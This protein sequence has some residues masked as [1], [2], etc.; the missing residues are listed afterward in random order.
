MKSKALSIVL[1]AAAIGGMA[2]SSSAAGDG[3]II[4]AAVACASMLVGIVDIVLFAA[5]SGSPL[6]KVLAAVISAG[7]IVAATAVTA[8]TLNPEAEEA[9]A[10][11]EAEPAVPVQ[12]YV[13]EAV[14][15]EAPVPE[16]EI[17]EAPAL[18]VRSQ[19]LVEEIPE[20]LMPAEVPVEPEVR[21][22]SAPALSVRSQEVIEAVPPA[23]V[24]LPP[25]P[26]PEPP[27]E[28]ETVV[29][30]AVKEPVV[31]SETIYGYTIT[32]SVLDGTAVVEYP[33]AVTRSD[34]EGF[35]AYEASK[36]G[37]A[38][39]GITYSIADGSSTLHIPASDEVIIQNVPQF[40]A[41]IAE[42]IDFLLA[43]KAEEEVEEIVVEEAVKEPVVISETIYGYTITVSVLDGTAVVEYPA[44]V[45]K[46]DAAGFY[47]YE[48]SKYGSAVD[49]I[50]YSLADGSSTLH[51]PASD[52]VIIQNVP[53]FFADIVEYIDF[54]F[55]SKAEEEVEEI[56]VEEAAEELPVPDAPV[57]D[58][59]SILIVYDEVAEE[60]AAAAALPVVLTKTIY[61]YT[62][63]VSVLDG[64]AVVE[65]PAIVTKSDAAGFYAYEVG[66]YG[67]YIDG[68][69][70]S[71]AD[72]SS[73][74]YV[75]LAD[76]AIVANADV[77]F[78][79]I[80]EYIG[81]LQA[82]A[83]TE[84]EEIAIAEEAGFVPVVITESVLGYTLTATVNEDTVG[85]AYPTIVTKSDAEGF[86][87]YELDK[88]GEAVLDGVYYT[89]SD[90]SSTL[91]IPEGMTTE[92]VADCVPVLVD[93]IIEYVTAL[94]AVS[95][96]TEPELDVRTITVTEPSSVKE[97]KLVEV[98]VPE[99]PEL[100]YTVYLV[101]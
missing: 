37:S 60:E 16:P 50:T 33:S 20:E 14:E 6:A 48:V 78:D 73:T 18:D 86:F 68:I 58:V 53:Q 27:A 15:P 65:Y 83:E 69:T 46:S 61:G 56:V 3:S 98:V 34:A 99:A 31:I 29:E 77:F 17:P 40:F 21:V 32:V 82:P 51:I 25:V 12:P 38:V 91:T 49:G 8:I 9:Q 92:A 19:D 79:D 35:F 74:L 10:E 95:V 55:S 62:V 81:T 44:I 11:A 1:L 52:E 66:K 47:A 57:M 85:L 94:T 5:S 97:T 26:E 63:T 71:L 80:V 42:Y 4:P 67:S 93:D 28:P 70:Y 45:T 96:P 23:V 2:W 72:G 75:P 76:D 39:D 43:S 36:Y 101:D 41:D 24:I 89:A 84:V 7:L 100:F 59:Q 87:A 54:L 88:Y 64:T 30:E 13:P 22:P 90:G